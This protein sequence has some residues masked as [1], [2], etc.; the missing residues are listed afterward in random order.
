MFYCP[1]AWLISTSYV[2]TNTSYRWENLLQ[3]GSR[4]GLSAARTAWANIAILH[5][6]KVQR[7][8]VMVLEKKP[9]SK[10]HFHMI[11][12]MFEGVTTVVKTMWVIGIIC[13]RVMFSYCG[14]G[15]LQANWYISPHNRRYGTVCNQYVFYQMSC[16]IASHWYV[17]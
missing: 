4:T 13:T 11:K 17:C 5:D 12:G 15:C 1:W 10:I 14:L 9:A 8:K 16:M 7:N 6:R 2:L 3:R